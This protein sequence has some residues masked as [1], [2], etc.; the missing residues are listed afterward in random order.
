[1]SSIQDTAKGYK[2][3]SSIS[4]F[5]RRHWGTISG[6]ILLSAVVALFSENFL[7]MANITNVFRQVSIN[8]I[9]AIG[10][11]CVILLGGVDLT[12]GS[13]VASAGC[14]VVVLFESKGLP[15]WLA[16]V[17]T[18]LVGAI[19]GCINGLFVA[20][21]TL[22]FFIITLSMQNIVR[23]L[24]YLFT[25]GYPVVSNS[26]A[27]NKFGNGQFSWTI[28]NIQFDLPYPVILM[29]ALFVAFGLMLSRS[30]F[31]RHMYATGGNKEAAI[32]SGINVKK[33]YIIVFTL[34]SILASISGIVLA[35][36]MYSGQPT[37]GTGYEGEAIAASVLGGV[38]FGGGYG[39]ITCTVIG[40]LIMGVIN[41]GMN[42]MKLDFF[43][44][45]IAKGVVTLGA[46]YLDSIKGSFKGIFKKK[47]VK[48]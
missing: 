28:G 4:V 39:S 23:G 38:S 13:T 1:M 12:V 26:E 5:F 47:E 44:Q 36:R 42:M 48:A 21:T 35:S 24:A 41:N 29:V 9:I 30:K 25:A 34:S 20:Y 7:T 37:V 22:P 33:I 40:T 8:G 31:G 15:V 16:I 3:T 6:L 45:L 10:L 32:H 46:V 18:L 14:L 17:I 19:I 11:T 27:F 43:Y 2:R